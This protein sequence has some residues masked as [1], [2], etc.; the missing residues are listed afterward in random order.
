MKPRPARVEQC[1]RAVASAVGVCQG[2]ASPQHPGEAVMLSHC[3]HPDGCVAQAS[4]LV[5]LLMA[6]LVPNMPPL[7]ADAA[8]R[9]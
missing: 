3:V 5:E 9:M 4:P 6:T 8:R 1:E 7:P 2:R